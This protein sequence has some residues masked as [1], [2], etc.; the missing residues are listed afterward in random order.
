MSCPRL[1]GGE[2]GQW[3]GKVGRSWGSKPG[4][5]ARSVKPLFLPPGLSSSPN[6]RLRHL[7][8][9]S[10]FKVSGSGSELKESETETGACEQKSRSEN[11]DLGLSREP[12]TIRSKGLMEPLIQG[13][14]TCSEPSAEVLQ[15]V[16][17]C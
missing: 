6:S 15:T 9:G 17:W 10:G 8:G 3:G 7:G 4:S 1:R 13:F 12:Q 16:G 11:S 14:Q 2:A 5:R